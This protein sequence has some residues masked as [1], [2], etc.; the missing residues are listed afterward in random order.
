MIKGS[1]AETPLQLFHFNP[2]HKW[3]QFDD[4]I[5]HR[6]A[7]GKAALPLPLTSGIVLMRRAVSNSLPFCPVLVPRS[8]VLPPSCS[9]SESLLDR[10]VDQR[11]PT[12]PAA[13]AL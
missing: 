5:S 8:A 3:E 13:A 2:A 6:E 12:V 7:S 1:P 9:V 4:I 10:T 11:R